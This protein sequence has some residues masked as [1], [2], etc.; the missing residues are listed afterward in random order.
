MKTVVTTR[1]KVCLNSHNFTH[2]NFYN[3]IY[4]LTQLF[5]VKNFLPN[6]FTFF[7]VN[8]KPRDHRISI[9]HPCNN[10]TRMTF[11]STIHPIG[12]H[13]L[14]CI[15]NKKD[16]PGAARPTRCTEQITHPNAAVLFSPTH[17]FCSL[18]TTSPLVR[19]DVFNF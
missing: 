19:A 8:H 2:K 16:D 14:H 6:L 9:T 5:H 17:C 1:N 4:K 11:G 12:K 3:F 13:Q 10:R 18:L 15:G 7:C